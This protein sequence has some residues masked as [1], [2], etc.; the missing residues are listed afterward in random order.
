[1][2][3]WSWDLLRRSSAR[4]SQS[5]SRRRKS[6]AHGL[7]I[8]F[9]DVLQI[10][11]IFFMVRNHFNYFHSKTNELVFN[12]FKTRDNYKQQRVKIDRKLKNVLRRWRKKKRAEH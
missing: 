12:A 11:F 3:A 9:Q 8:D 10:V 2:D 5:W 7:G 6:A 4:D 1:M